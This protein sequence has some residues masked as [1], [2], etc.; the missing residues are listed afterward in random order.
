MTVYVHDYRIEGTAS[1]GQ[2]WVVASAI[3]V[4]PNPLRLSHASVM[5]QPIALSTMTAPAY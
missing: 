4:T 5:N 3:S 2:T 1:D